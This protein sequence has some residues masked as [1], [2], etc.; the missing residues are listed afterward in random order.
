[1]SQWLNLGQLATRA[2]RLLP[3][4]TN[5]TSWLTQPTQD[6]TTLNNVK[7]VDA[8]LTD[9]NCLSFDGLDDV[10]VFPSTLDFEDDK[11]YSVTLTFDPTA[12]TNTCFFASSTASNSRFAVSM[13]SGDNTKLV[14]AVRQASFT[15]VE[16]P[17]SS[18]PSGMIT[19]TASWDGSSTLTASYVDSG[20]STTNFTSSSEAAITSGTAKTVLGARSS[21]SSHGILNSSML[22]IN[23]DNALIGKYPLA[24]GSGT[25]AYDISGNGNHGTI[26]GATWTTEDGI[27]SWNHQYGHDLV[28]VLNGTV[29]GFDTGIN[30]DELDMYEIKIQ[31]TGDQADSGNF[32]FVEIPHGNPSL[33]VSATVS[34][35]GYRLTLLNA[36]GGGQDTLQQTIPNCNSG[37]FN[38]YKVDYTNPSS[39]KV[40]VNGN[41]ELTSTITVSPNSSRFHIGDDSSI[42]A[43]D[44]GFF[45]YFKGWKDGVLKIHAVLDPSGRVRDLVSGNLLTAD[46]GGTG[47]LGLKRIPALNTKTKQV[48]T[49]DGAADQVNTGYQPTGDFVVDARIKPHSITNQKTIH[50]CG[51]G[52]GN[53]GYWHRISNAELQL[54]VAGNYLIGGNSGNNNSFASANTLYD[55]RVEYTA[56]TNSWVLKAKEATDSTYTTLGSGTATPNFSTANVVLGQK[57][58]G[59]FF[60]GEYHSFKLTD[61]GVDKVE[62]DFQNDIG[63]TTVQD[64]TT[65][66]NDGTVTAG[67][68]GTDSFWGQR[69]ADNDGVLVSA[70]Y[71]T[72][73]G[74]TFNNAAGFVHNKSECGLDLVTNDKTA[75]ELFAIDNSTATETFAKK[76]ADGNITQVLDYSAALTGN[77]LTRTRNYVG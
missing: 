36:G 11:Q 31:S 49:F 27:E 18:I 38:V 12:G 2:G 44:N 47:S 57:G 71:A 40:F 48:A 19:L 76:D 66:D 10:L 50:A 32:R 65:N 73:N 45:Y 64:L 35:D 21:L 59:G 24:E 4:I 14:V 33:F 6:G 51:T 68:G 28:G 46:V 53:S 55:T 69:V 29:S 25:T 34:G 41:L 61:G 3:T 17:F 70:D 77:D 43:L 42:N 62:Y 30:G 16:T 7:G 39:V 63:T 13:A 9:V 15:T 75:T 74:T 52:D 1:M 8:E 72:L 20:G 58:N 23:K 60:D 37:Q 22:I 26:T 54:Y 56:S 67:S 5:L